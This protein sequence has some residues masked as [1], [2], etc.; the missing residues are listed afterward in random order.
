[1]RKFIVY[2]DNINKKRLKEKGRDFHVNARVVLSEEIIN[3]KATEETK[4][5]YLNIFQSYTY[6]MVYNNEYPILIR[7]DAPLELRKKVVA[8]ALNTI[9]G[10]WDTVDDALKK[11]IVVI[12]AKEVFPNKPSI[13]ETLRNRIYVPL[14]ETPTN[15]Q[16]VSDDNQFSIISDFQQLPIESRNTVEKLIDL[17][18]HAETDVVSGLNKIINSQHI[19][20]SEYQQLSKEGQDI[21]LKLIKV[22]KKADTDINISLKT[23]TKMFY[24]ERQ[25]EHKASQEP[26]KLE[27]KK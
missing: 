5:E 20:F 1:M 2:S 25:K 27:D 21:I 12:G 8:A 6:E 13:D 3:A 9:E 18:K 17:L 15:K 14:D 26:N 23:I 4:V 22:L 11:E 10:Q 24:N 16:P 7:M 19:L